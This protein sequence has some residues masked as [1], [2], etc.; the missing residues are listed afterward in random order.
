MELM[1][2]AHVPAGAGP[3]PTILALHGFGAS[4]HDLLGIAPLVQ[5][6]IPGDGVLFL[7]PQGPIEIEPA[8]GQRAYAW[9]PLVGEGEIDPMSLIAARGVLE[10]FVEDAIEAYPIDPERLVIMG[11]SQGG[12][13]A[14][15]LAL[16]R[17]ERFKALIAL[18]SWLPDLIVE[19]LQPNEA[20][21]ALATL[22][23]HGTEDPMIAIDNGRDS[24]EKLKALGIAAAWGEYEMGHEI[25][26]NA[27]RDLLDW[28]AQGPLG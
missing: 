19:G 7:C 26:Q 11:F 9:F 15:D 4:A 21:E 18:S 23:V 27:L 28:L 3:F 2:T 12:V 17:P 13:M 5:Q 10:A 22:L 6:A 25:N 14:Y 20:R 8:P 1:H 24:L 16:G